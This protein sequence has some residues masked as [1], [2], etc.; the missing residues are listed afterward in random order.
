MSKA[1]TF[2]LL[3][4]DEVSGSVCFLFRET[5]ALCSFL[6][7]SRLGLDL[8]SLTLLQ[9]RALL[10]P[11]KT[12]KGISYVDRWRNDYLHWGPV[13]VESKVAKTLN[14]FLSEERP[15]GDLTPTHRAN[16]DNSLCWPFRI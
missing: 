11:L 1:C 3:G 16:G 9:S 8:L 6:D 10:S 7:L 14:A 5:I 4:E 13:Y 12:Q 2:V 15:A